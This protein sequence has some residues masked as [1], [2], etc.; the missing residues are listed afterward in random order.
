MRIT[1]Y[2]YSKS[3]FTA[4]LYVFTLTLLSTL[5]LPMLAPSSGMAATGDIK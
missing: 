1:L 4:K 3:M 2:V 5:L